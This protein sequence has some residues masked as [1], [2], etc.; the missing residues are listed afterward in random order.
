MS[1]NSKPA[2]FL[3]VVRWIRNVNRFEYI[4]KVTALHFQQVSRD[5]SVGTT[6]LRPISDDNA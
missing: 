1:A 5:D 2:F 3:G 4:N 6:D